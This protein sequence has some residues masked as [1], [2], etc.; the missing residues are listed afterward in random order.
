MKIKKC[1]CEHCESK[2]KPIEFS[3]RKGFELSL[4]RGGYFCKNIFFNITLP[5]GT[6]KINLPMVTDLPKGCNPPHYGIAIHGNIFWIYLGGKFDYSSDQTNDKWI[7]WYLPWFDRVHDDEFSA[8]LNKENKWDKE[9]N[10]YSDSDWTYVPDEWMYIPR[11]AQTQ[12]IKFKDPYDGEETIAC[13]YMSRR[14]WWRKWFKWLPATYLTCYYC[15]FQFNKEV[16]PNKNY[17]KGGVIVSS[18]QMEKDE[19]KYSALM[20]WLEKK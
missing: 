7:T 19:S 8:I 4:N 6:M 13:V 18:I 17:W 2:Y 3:E 9:I 10:D 14:R 16:G 12:Y 1:N 5:I 15:G 20:R 11:N